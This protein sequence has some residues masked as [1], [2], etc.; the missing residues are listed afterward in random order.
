MSEASYVIVEILNVVVRRICFGKKIDD[1][2]YDRIAPP[3]PVLTK[4]G[5][6]RGDFTAAAAG[7][8][9]PNG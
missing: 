3:W 2:E 9:I 1:S 4:F 8:C 6:A 5:S 7:P